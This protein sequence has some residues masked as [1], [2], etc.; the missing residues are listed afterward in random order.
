M[1]MKP[2]S[3]ELSYL[4]LSSSTFFNRKFRTFSVGWN[5][6]TKTQIDMKV[7]HSLCQMQNL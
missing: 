4:P 2:T 3:N 1:S 5:K 6:K 7:W